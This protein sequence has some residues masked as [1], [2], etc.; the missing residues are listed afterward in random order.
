MKVLVTGYKGQLGYDVIRVLRAR[1]INCLGVD[2]EEFDITNAKDTTRFITDYAPDIVVHC[3]AYTAVDRAEEEPA[4]CYAVNAEGTRNIAAACKAVDAALIYISTDYVFPGTGDT[5][6]ETNSKTGPLS[7]YGRTKLAGETAVQELL[8]RF[9]IVRISWVFGV[10]G[11]NFVTSML[12]H[13]KDKESMRVVSDQIGSPTYTYDLALLLCNLLTTTR[14]G[15]YHVTNEGYCSWAD[16]AEEIFRLAGYDTK[17]ERIPAAEYPSKAV[18]PM[19]SRLSK[20]CLVEQG[21]QKLP[22]WQDALQRFFKEL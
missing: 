9:F 19:N 10:N 4:L 6:Y 5:P 2:R 8:T 21:F 20:D 13:G 7:E 12:T 15:I 3:A 17:V 14:Y 22:A 1:Q 18:R 16:F 11:K